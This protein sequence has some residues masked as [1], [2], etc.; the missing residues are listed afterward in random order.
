ML[1]IAHAQASR[2]SV[3]VVLQFGFG[4]L[5]ILVNVGSG[6]CPYT[7][8]FVRSSKPVKVRTLAISQNFD[9]R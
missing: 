8:P 3:S 9:W 4:Q 2:G 5:M 6:K 7:W 1:L